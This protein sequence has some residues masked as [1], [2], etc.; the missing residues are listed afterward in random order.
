MNIQLAVKAIYF[1]AIKQGTKFY[2]FR[3]HNDYW[4]KRLLGRDY[5]RLIITNGYPSKEDLEKRFECDYTGFIVKHLTHPHFGNKRI[6]VFAIRIEDNFNKLE[7]QIEVYDNQ[8][9]A[10]LTEKDGFI[11][12]LYPKGL[13]L[14]DSFMDEELAKK[15]VFK[16]KHNLEDLCFH[17]YH[18][19]R[20]YNQD[21][22]L[23][24]K[25]CY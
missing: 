6:K 13:L 19:V 24:S 25:I 8:Y 17:K 2:E 1:D 12:D 22:E 9:S 20:E 15:E 14:S 10:M 16:V 4:S 3:E 7:Q 21:L 5:E 11:L 18:T 23:I